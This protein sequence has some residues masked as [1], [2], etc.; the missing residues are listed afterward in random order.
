M[1]A[2]ARAL[3]ILFSLALPSCGWLDISPERTPHAE[4]PADWRGSAEQAI[5]DA[6]R[7]PD[8]ARFTQWEKSGES[9]SVSVDAK[10]AFG[11]YTGRRLWSVFWDPDGSVHASPFG[12]NIRDMAHLRRFAE[13]Y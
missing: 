9:V 10:N 4:P 8:G 5:R 3:L 11:A 12:G 1:L 6:L 7:N 13:D 2:R